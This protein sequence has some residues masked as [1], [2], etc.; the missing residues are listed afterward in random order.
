MTV[1]SKVVS[2]LNDN[3]ITT[4]IMNVY[5]QDILNH[6]VAGTKATSPPGEKFSVQ[7]TG[8][9]KCQLTVSTI[10]RPPYKKE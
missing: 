4:S 1:R 5:A 10:V 6:K 2:Q 3:T 9:T 8:E 7:E